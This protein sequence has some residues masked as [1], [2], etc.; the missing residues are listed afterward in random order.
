M[1]AG[2]RA[3]GGEAWWANHWV[4]QWTC[5]GEDLENVQKKTG[6]PSAKI[7]LNLKSKE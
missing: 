4:H 7:R 5:T 6:I 3:W 2:A 1:G